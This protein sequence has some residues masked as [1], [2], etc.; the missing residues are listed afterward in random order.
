MYNVKKLQDSCLLQ[1]YLKDGKCII[2]IRGKNIWVIWL[3][4]SNSYD[5]TKCVNIEIKNSKIEKVTDPHVV[6]LRE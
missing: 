6:W 4:L 1:N 2:W 3:T 5:F